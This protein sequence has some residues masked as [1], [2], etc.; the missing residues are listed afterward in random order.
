MSLPL[1]AVIATAGGNP[2]LRDTLRSLAACERPESYRKTIL[3]E[4]GKPAGAEAV[5]AEV[6]AEHPGFACEYLYS[7]RA[8]KS[9]ALNA[10]LETLNENC[11]LFLS[12]DDIEFDPGI[13]QAYASA[14]EGSENGVAYGGPVRVRTTGEVPPELRYSLPPSA[15][16]FPLGEYS[17]D[18]DFL[19]ANWAVS[20]DDLN[21]AGGFDPRFGP[22]S[23][24]TATGQESEMMR[25]LRRLGCE[26]R[27][28]PEAVIWHHFDASGYTTDFL[29][30]RKYRN[31]VEHGIRMRLRYTEGESLRWQQ[32][33]RK[34]RL[35]TLLLPLA[36][37]FARLLAPKEKHARM[38]AALNA[39]RGRL[40]G[41]HSTRAAETTTTR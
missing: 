20:R 27:Y 21:A 30:R 32:D 25:Q 12:D 7:E 24:L 11:L 37:P 40:T 5:V 22:G 8:N 6:N 13:L 34:S 1:I 4:N 19:G 15:T 38:V 33:L 39:A 10:C 18:Q 17:D 9:S 31:G 41:W 35:Y 26:F 14:A 29:G 16:G 23:P 2:R 28:V 36:I 3:V